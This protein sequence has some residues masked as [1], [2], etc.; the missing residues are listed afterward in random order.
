[1]ATFWLCFIPLFV[2]VDAIG[3]LPFFMSLTE[4][5]ER[6]KLRP[7]IIQSTLTAMLVS[8]LFLIIG[9][10]L[11]RSLNIT[12][13]DFMIAG[14]SLL[15]AISLRDMLA[16]EKKHNS[17]DYDSIGAVPLGVPLIVGPAVLTTTILLIDQ[18]GSMITVAALVANV[19]IAGFVFTLSAPISKIIGKAGSKTVSK[20][21]NIIL[22]SIAVMLIRR[23]IIIF[24]GK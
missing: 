11:L 7:I 23:G 21:S 9:K 10:F 12:V 14:G 16:S 2:A 17:T 5:L 6:E 19:L 1:M 13:A 4:G 18:Y 8:V 20:L 22:A 24:L 15:F 3:V